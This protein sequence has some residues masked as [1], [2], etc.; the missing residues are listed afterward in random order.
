[1]PSWK[2]KAME[3]S[4]DPNACPF[5]GSW[6]TESSMDATAASTEDFPAMYSGDGSNDDHDKATNAKIQGSDLK[7]SGDYAG[8]IDSFTEAILAA[9]PSA[10]LLANRAHC[11]FKLSRYDAAIRDC[12][13]ALQRN[14]DS[15]KALRIRGECK[16]KLEKYH[17]ALVDLSAAQAIDFDE[18]AALMLKETTEKCS[19]IDAM[20]VKRKNEEEDKLRKRAEEIKKAREEAAK[21]QSRSAAGGGGFGGGG[22]GMGGGGMPGGMGGMGGMQG[23][24]AGLMVSLKSWTKSAVMVMATINNYRSSFY[25]KIKSDPEIAAG[26]Q[27]P[28]VMQAFQDLM[29][30]PGGPMGLMSNPSKLQEMMADPE[31]RNSFLF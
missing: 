9:E 25:R 14:P 16:L 8:A 29:S 19:E 24:M 2:R 5:G 4:D 23:M 17:E 22:M 3:T 21:E 10:L 6:K 7:S 12:N 31:V 15:A 13:E 1:M 28:K 30:G 11:L 26:M 20:K 18:E 27:N